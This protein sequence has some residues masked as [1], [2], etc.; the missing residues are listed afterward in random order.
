MIKIENLLEEKK[1]KNK[2][3]NFRLDFQR[4]V[5]CQVAVDGL[6]GWSW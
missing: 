3:Q 2:E 6:I 1:K 5:E 4:E